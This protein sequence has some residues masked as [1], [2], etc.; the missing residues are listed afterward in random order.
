[1]ISVMVPDGKKRFGGI[2]IYYDVFPS[3]YTIQLYVGMGDRKRKT[4]DGERKVESG[5]RMSD[6]AIRAIHLAPYI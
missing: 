5:N 1:M 3:L 4:E 6:G 2:C